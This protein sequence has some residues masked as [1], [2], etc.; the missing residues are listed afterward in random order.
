VVLCHGGTPL[1]R[2]LALFTVA[3]RKL[4]ERGY[5][6]LAVD[7]RGFGDSERPP[8]FETAA[9]LDF[10]QDVTAAVDYL[11]TLRRVD[12]SR[13]GV[14]GHSF[15]AGVAVAACCDGASAAV[16]VSP[17]RHTPALLRPER[18]DYS[19]PADV[20]DMGSGLRSR[21]RSSTRT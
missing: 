2:R 10:V 13:I 20:G 6:V 8:R 4:A 17:G 18:P 1:G 15:G 21:G 9:D 7:L 5:V 19:E 14:V 12:G 11:A 3:A 16:S